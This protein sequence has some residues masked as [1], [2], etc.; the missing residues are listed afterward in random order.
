MTSTIRV[1]P[2]D[3]AVDRFM[4]DAYSGSIGH[5]IAVVP[6]GGGRVYGD[7]IAVTVAPDGLTATLELDTNQAR[8]R[9]DLDQIEVA[10]P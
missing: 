3:Y 8:Q 4:A 1:H 9:L 7:L 10:Q 2:A 6:A 5:L